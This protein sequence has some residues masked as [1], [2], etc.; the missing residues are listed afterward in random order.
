MFCSNQVPLAISAK[1]ILMYLTFEFNL[2]LTKVTEMQRL[3][4]EHS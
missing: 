3:G 4:S 1:I 2:D